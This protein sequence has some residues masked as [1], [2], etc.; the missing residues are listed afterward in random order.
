[1]LPD[2]HKRKPGLRF[3]VREGAPNAL[4]HGLLRGEYDLILSPLSGENSQLITQPLF[5]EPLKFVTP[6][7]HKLSGKAYVKPEEINDLQ[8]KELARNVAKKI[9]TDSYPYGHLSSNPDWALVYL[10]DFAAVYFK[11][12]PEHAGVISAN[13]YKFLTPENFARGNVFN[14]VNQSS[15]RAL[16]DELLRQSASDKSSVTSLLLLAEIFYASKIDENAL[17]LLKEAKRRQPYNKTIDEMTDKISKNAFKG[18]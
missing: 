11:R 4:Q 8:A 14:E 5:K 17:I 13:E 1:V 3:Y 16:T 7:D 15:A 18:M 10:D 2:L 9:E 12:I 6:S